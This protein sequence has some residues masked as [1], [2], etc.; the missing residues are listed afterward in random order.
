MERAVEASDDGDV[1]AAVVRSY[2]GIVM[3]PSGWAGLLKADRSTLPEDVETAQREYVA[4][5]AQLIPLPGYQALVLVHAALTFI[6]DFSRT[7]HLNA[8]HNIQAVSE[9]LAL[10]VL[11]V[12]AAVIKPRTLFQAEAGEVL[13]GRS[14][15]T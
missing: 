2:I 8:Q 15:A 5:W 10:A 7:P 4:H 9:R 14:P 6:N 13:R 3:G 11:D 12:D 1:I